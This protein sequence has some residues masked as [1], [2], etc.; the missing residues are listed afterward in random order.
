MVGTVAFEVSFMNVWRGRDIAFD[1]V[2]KYAKENKYLIYMK[3][4][5]T[6]SVKE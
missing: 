1:S 3:Y 6:I 4:G 5:D 2:Q